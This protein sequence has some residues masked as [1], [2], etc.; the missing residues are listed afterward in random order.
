M[1]L[2]TDNNRAL[3]DLLANP[4][5][6]KKESTLFAA[7]A[8]EAL[9]PLSSS[10]IAEIYVHLGFLQSFLQFLG[11]EHWIQRQARKEV[12]YESFLEPLLK[13]EFSSMAFLHKFLKNS[14][15]TEASILRDKTQC[16][17]SSLVSLIKTKSPEEQKKISLRALELL[18]SL[19][20]V[21]NQLQIEKKKQGS[22]LG[23]SLY[24]SFDSL[25]EIFCLSYS[26]DHGMKQDLE[27]TE[28][29]YEGAGV[30]V[31][32][33]YSTILTALRYLKPTQGSR[34][35]DLGSGYGRVGLVIGLLRP[36]IDFTG[37]EY[38]PHRVDIANAAAKSFHLESH[39][40][41]LAQ[42]LA[43]KNFQI[44]EADIYYMYDP[45]SK[46]TYEYVLAQLL[47]IS[48]KRKISIATKGNARQ[49]LMNL[50]Q[51][52]QWPTPEEFDSGNICLFH[53]QN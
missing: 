16:L 40:H 22:H 42:D 38:V 49:K 47:T 20:E 27:G 15:L 32:S 6:S 53:S 43:Q 33:G 28:R 21:E 25:D 29:L 46:E 7:S 51:R 48:K 45:F 12:I 10:D 19:F 18:V 50:V 9:S 1:M 41:F 5:F 8:R 13:N 3:I 26:A 35:I 52:H 37:Y 14:S 39:V 2:M 23:F 17:E 44:P 36:D 24:R 30:G 31:Q 4:L 11:E 34:I